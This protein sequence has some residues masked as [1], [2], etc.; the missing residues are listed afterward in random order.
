MVVAARREHH[1][2][3]HHYSWAGGDPQAVRRTSR[4]AQCLK[5]MVRDGRDTKV[6]G[7][8]SQIRRGKLW[9]LA[10]LPPG[11]K[12]ISGSQLLPRSTSGSLA[13]QHGLWWYLF[14][15]VT[16]KGIE[17]WTT[18]SWPLTLLAAAL[19]RT[20]PAPHQLRHSRDALH[21]TWTAQ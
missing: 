17:D 13:L 18:Q 21:S 3:Q 9:W 14:S 8:W 6:L 1:P 16:T 5:Y 19:W 15:L 4:P 10:C 11:T 7:L 20:G 2:A 12:A